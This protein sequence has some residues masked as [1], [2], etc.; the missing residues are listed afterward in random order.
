[1][2]LRVGWLC[3]GGGVGCNFSLVSSEGCEL[4]IGL[5]P[6]RAGDLVCWDVWK[7]GF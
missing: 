6:W 1:M 3:G 5:V 2:V 4:E 7:W